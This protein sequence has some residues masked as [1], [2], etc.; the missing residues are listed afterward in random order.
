MM[1]RTAVVAASAL[2]AVASIA[3]GSSATDAR[4]GQAAQANLQIFNASSIT[5]PD[6]QEV[7]V[8]C[9]NGAD[10][11]SL[12]LGEVYDVEAPAGDFEVTVYDDD[13]ATCADVPDRSL[14]VS[15]AAGDLK[16]VVI[17]YDT[18]FEIPIDTSC[19]FSQ[20]GRVQVANGSAMSE[21]LD[22]WITSPTDGTSFFVQAAMVPGESATL[23]NVLA[24]TYD[25]SGYSPGANPEVDPP[26][27][28]F[29]SFDLQSGYQVQAFLVGEDEGS[30][31]A[32]SFDYQQGPDPC[33]DEE[34]PP[35]STPTTAVTSTTAPA[36]SPGTATPAVPV[37]GAAAYT[38]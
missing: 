10:Q 31:L 34:L 5:Y 16:G 37:S 20:F 33:D 8:V 25:I 2:V 13:A 1:K 7:A 21:P 29:G 3:F 11:D 18:L 22:V 15:L 23:P 32:G 26:V 27:A 38:G 9:V 17:G 4:V 35:T 24:D 12:G 30:N 36:V 28:T 6:P 14:T 19:V